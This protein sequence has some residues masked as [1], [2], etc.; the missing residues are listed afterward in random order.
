MAA[1]RRRLIAAA[2]LAVA[3]LAVY[4]RSFGVPFLFD[5]LLAVPENPAIRTLSG[6][7]AT[8]SE[9]ALAGRPLTSLSFAA[10]HAAGGLAVGGYHAVNL[11]IHVLCAWLVWGVTRRLLS[12]SRVRADDAAAAEGL[13][14]AAALLWTVHPLATETVV[15]VVQRTESLMAL[16]LLATLYAFLR[17]VS[18]PRPGP[19]LVAS[20]AACALGMGCKQVMVVAP[21]VIWCADALFV[22]GS[23]GASLRKRAPY[24]AGLAATW[25]VLGFLLAGGEVARATG[26]DRDLGVTPLQYLWTQSRAILHYLRLT[27]WPTP[28]VLHYDWTAARSLREAWPSV[29]LVGALFAATAAGVWRRIPAAF[30]GVVFFLVLA[31]SSS[32][33]PIPTEL[34]A[35]RRMYVPLAA[36]LA[37]AVV[38]ARRALVRF[39]EGSVASRIAPAA[40]AALAVALGAAA[41]ARVRDYRTEESI[42]RDTVEKSPGSVVVRNNYGRALANLGRQDEAIAQYREGLR[43]RPDDARTWAKLGNALSEQG[44]LAEAVE[45]YR[46][47]LLYEPTD[48]KTHNNLARVL[49]RTGDLPGAIAHLQ[50]AVRLDPSYVLGRLNLA[51]LLANGGRFA[52]ARVELERV[53]A[54]PEAPADARA[55]AQAILA[56]LQRR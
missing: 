30:A 4:A 27:V 32:V 43:L 48:E 9:T 1:V 53:V 17:G 22:T 16:C 26:L 13:A 19:W 40:V 18:S 44:K 20:V 7:L 38:G 50:E 47:A 10:N 3:A 23:F 11:A 41:F 49:L 31:P 37:L 33:V 39:A 35:E 12:S 45:A 5:D 36:L 56:D 52:E 28:L 6:S 54:M 8:S 42:W 51:K 24:Y 55:G 14:L 2:I 21:L 29:A 25:T 34:V 15:Y 46:K